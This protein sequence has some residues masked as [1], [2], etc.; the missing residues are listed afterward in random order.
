MVMLED[1]C[2]TAVSSWKEQRC[3]CVHTLKSATRGYEWC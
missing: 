3:A 1:K 2:V